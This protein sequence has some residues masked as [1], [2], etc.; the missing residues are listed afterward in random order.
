MVFWSE[1]PMSGAILAFSLAIASPFLA[2]AEIVNVPHH[3]RTSPEM[4]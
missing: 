4:P 2:T 3:S 1:M